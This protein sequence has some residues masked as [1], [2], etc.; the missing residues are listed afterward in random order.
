MGGYNVEI[1]FS[2]FFYLTIGRR[3]QKNKTEINPTGCYVYMYTT[4]AHT[5]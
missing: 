3:K 4:H 1:P 5:E 2:F